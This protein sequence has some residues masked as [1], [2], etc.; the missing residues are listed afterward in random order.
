MLWR[1]LR[2]ALFCVLTSL[3]PGGACALQSQPPVKIEC[4]IK[5]SPRMATVV[6]AQDG[7]GDINIKP[8]EDATK[9][10]TKALEMA[11]KAR[12]TL[13]IREGVYTV[14]SS[15]LL[16][17]S[18]V[19]V[20]G[21]GPGRTV[22]RLVFGGYLPAVV[23]FAYVSNVNYKTGDENIWLEGLEIYA[24]QRTIPKWERGSRL[25][26]FRKVR[27]LVIRDCYF[28]E[29]RSGGVLHIWECEDVLVE[30]VRCERVAFQGGD[31]CFKLGGVVNGRLVNCEAAPYAPKMLAF[32]LSHCR[33]VQMV[34]CCGHDS[35]SGV[36][37][38]PGPK[39]CEDI[40]IVNCLFYNNRNEGIGICGIRRVTVANCICRDNV[41]HGIHVLSG[42]D[43]LTD[44]LTI[45]GCLCEGNRKGAGISLRGPRNF[46]VAG[47]VCRG[48]GTGIWVA[49]TFGA[50]RGNVCVDNLAEG[51]RV[52]RR[53]KVYGLEVATKAVVVEGNV[54]A[55]TKPGGPQKVG[56]LIEPGC[57]AVMAKGNLCLGEAREEGK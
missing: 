56:I 30:N 52:V 38:E 14:K 6:L 31:A 19:K 57:E 48:N 18:N 49:G 40:Q 55:N 43:W 41:H 21:C 26:V 29:A 28:H 46:S 53:H 13:L 47:N 4:A 12:G 2:R 34:N 35:L 20:V 45:V 51:I 9:A 33:N 27:N 8:E 36:W 50:I 54:C 11:S 37:V 23:G 5:P 24:D 39:G 3:I 25:I 42:R 10:L 1:Y 7:S 17:P 15:K 16:F 32:N 44:R 22:I